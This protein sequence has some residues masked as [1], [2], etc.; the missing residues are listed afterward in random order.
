MSMM[1]RG[2]EESEG[3]SVRLQRRTRRMEETG[4]VCVERGGKRCW[5]VEVRRLS[6]GGGLTSFGCVNPFSTS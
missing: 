3:S 1:S 5:N 4:V 6:S 2:S